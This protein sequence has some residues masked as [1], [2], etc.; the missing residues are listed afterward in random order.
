[1]NPLRYNL[2]GRSVILNYNLI[3]NYMFIII[4]FG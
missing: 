2:T 4:Y 1:M 3:I